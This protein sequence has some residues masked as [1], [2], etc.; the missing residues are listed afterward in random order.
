MVNSMVNFTLDAA[1]N[2]LNGNGYDLHARRSYD[3]AAVVALRRLKL[4]VFLWR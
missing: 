4:L 1:V 3:A 2:S